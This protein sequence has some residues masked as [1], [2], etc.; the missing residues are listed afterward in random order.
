[1]TRHIAVFVG[2]I[3]GLS[4][5][6]WGVR[7]AT[8]PP[9]MG[10]AGA[11]VGV[12]VKGEPADRV[13]ELYS[14]D[15]TAL[16]I[17]ASNRLTRIGWQRLEAMDVDKLARA[18]D[19]R[20]G[21]TVTADKRARLSALSRFPGGINRDLLARLLHKLGQDS[22]EVI[23]LVN[24]DS[25]TRF[26]ATAT[27]RYMDRRIAAAEGYRRVGADFPGM[28]EHWVH[29][30]VI[31][32][33]RIDPRRPTMLT[34]ATIAGQARL[35]GLG[36]IVTTEGG[37]T[38]RD[39][40]G[41]PGFWHEH[42]GLLSEE[43]GA[44]LSR[45]IEAIGG[46]RVW[47]LHAWTGLENPAGRYAADNWAL[48]F[49]RAGVDPPGSFSEEAARALSLAVGG[50]TFVANLLADVGL[51]SGDKHRST[52]STIAL[53]RARAERTLRTMREGSVTGAEVSDLAATWRDLSAAL[54]ELHGPHVTALL[55][56]SHHIKDAT[57]HR[58]HAP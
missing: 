37:L 21:E 58:S 24:I 55:A 39:L 35:L 1:M 38:P 45:G 12:R 18:Y 52:D 31:L 7:P 57:S 11:L 15:S 49:A 23:A 50:D 28:G 47:V 26:A 27:A 53:A 30:T 32:S 17:L 9:A 5:C 43:S 3:A 40:P 33:G 44:K 16:M 8:F 54:A 6:H 46:T 48:P 19:I 20:P 42:S 41:W 13:G 34:Y 56:P 51:T 36:F 14:V 2:L 10:P 29:P 4:G 22:V 25:L